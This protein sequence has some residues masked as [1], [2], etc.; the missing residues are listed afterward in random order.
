VTAPHARPGS[1][2]VDPH[3]RQY[4][5]ISWPMLTGQ[6]LE[7]TLNFRF[8]R[9][10]NRLNGV[11][12]R[13]VWGQE[14]KPDTCLFAHGI[15]FFTPADFLNK[16]HTGAQASHCCTCVTLLHKCH[17]VAQ[18]SH[19]SKSVTL[20][21]KGHTVAHVS[22]CCTS[23]T[24]LHKCHTVAKVSHCCIRVTLLHKCH[25]VAKVSHSC[26]RVTLLHKGRPTKP[27][28]VKHADTAFCVKNKGN[29]QAE[30][31]HCAQAKTRATHLW[32][33]QLYTTRTLRRSPVSR[34]SSS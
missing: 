17:P 20:L 13:E 33:A 1:H 9:M 32:M 27:D 4:A 5:G 31:I 6:M 30:A 28:S 23:V 21:H 15:K 22:P 24:L 16:R 18:A 12:L 3:V 26:I 8:V 11:K 34:P 25:T 19:W 10:E 29:E 2:E 14:Q 7:F